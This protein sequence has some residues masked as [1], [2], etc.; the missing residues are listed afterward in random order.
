MTEQI[1]A[2]VEMDRTSQAIDIMLAVGLQSGTRYSAHVQIPANTTWDDL[3]QAW[4]QQAEALGIT[5]RSRFQV[6]AS[7]F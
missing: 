1:I 2:Q 5:Q 4:N 6:I 7:A 3:I